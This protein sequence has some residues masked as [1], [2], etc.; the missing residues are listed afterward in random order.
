MSDRLCLES[1]WCGNSWYDAE[2]LA[3]CRLPEGHEGW[4]WADVR[5]GAV[6]G[7]VRWVA[8]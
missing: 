2:D 1:L 8:S 5:D 6:V 3:Q 7:S 4:H